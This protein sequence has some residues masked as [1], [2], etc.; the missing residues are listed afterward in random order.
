MKAKGFMDQGLLV[1]DEIVLGL[2]EEVLTS[3]EAKRGIVMDGFPRTDQQADAVEALLVTRGSTVDSAVLID[4]SDDEL[5]KRLR[6]RAVQE[7]R[8]DDTPEAIARR[9]RV[10]REQTAPLIDYYRKRGKLREVPGTGTVEEIAR[11]IRK[12]LGI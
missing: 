3:P 5:V 2:I 6:G 8:T 12:A 10:Y 4:V 9:L 1:P 11:R 7:G